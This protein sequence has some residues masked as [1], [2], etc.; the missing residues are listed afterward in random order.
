MTGLWTLI[1]VVVVALGF[2]TYRRVTDGRGRAVTRAT[3][4]SEFEGELGE[5]ATFV[6][7]SSPVCAPCHAT[8]RILGSLADERPGIAVVDVDVSERLDLAE[9]H[10]VSR[11]PTVLVLDGAGVVRQR[12]VGAPTRVRALAA[13]DEALAA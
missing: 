2:G 4:V 10:G 6:Q 3:P 11:T 5:K 13:L 7:F 8:R 12:I 1:V 9:L